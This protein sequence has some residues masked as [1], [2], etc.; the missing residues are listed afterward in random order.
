MGFNLTTAG[1]T[2]PDPQNW[3]RIST[4]TGALMNVMDET[5][6][7]SGFNISWGGTPTGPLFLGTST[8]APDATPQYDYDLSGMTGY[9]FRAGS[10]LTFNLSGLNPDTPYEYWIVAYRGGGFIDTTA[11]ISD[12]DSLDAT[13][14]NQF[15]AFDD[16]DGRFVVNTAASSDSQNWNDLSFITNSSSNG[17]LTININ[18]VSQITVLGAFAIREIPTPGTAAVLIAPLLLGARRRR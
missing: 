13:T 15:L 4:T 11:S 10:E 17:T 6:A 12:G 16:N 9:G 5:G 8:L 18:G 7:P 1:N 14:F 2:T 3:N